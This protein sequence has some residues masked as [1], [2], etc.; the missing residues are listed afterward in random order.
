MV[1]NKK[2]AKNSN[3]TVVIVFDERKRGRP[4]PG[5]ELTTLSATKPWVALGMSRRTFFR[6]K[7]DERL[8]KEMAVDG[9]EDISRLISRSARAG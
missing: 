5:E 3:T 8:K 4:K 2:M 9:N 1:N 7:A 6:R